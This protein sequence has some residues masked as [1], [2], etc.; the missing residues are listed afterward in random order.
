M[1]FSLQC[2]YTFCRM[3]GCTG[4]LVYYLAT[5]LGLLGG[6]GGGA[7]GVEG[8]RKS[9]GVAVVLGAGAPGAEESVELGEGVS[10]AG[11]SVG[12]VVVVGEEVS[13]AWESVGVAVE[14]SGVLG[15]VESVE[16]GGGL[17]VELGAGISVETDSAEL[18]D[19]V[20]SVGD[21]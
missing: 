13:G 11:E 20:D 15:A 6:R 17:E 5:F 14:L 7:D 1:G 10:G 8:G 21:E 19:I 4:S 18:E 12:M 3:T 16:A 2:V 9:V